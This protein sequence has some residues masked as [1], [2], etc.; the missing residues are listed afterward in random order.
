MNSLENPTD[1]WYLKTGNGEIY[2]PVNLAALQRWAAAGRIT[3]DALLSPDQAKWKPAY[4]L[5]ALAMNCVV[6]IRPGAFYG[7]LHANAVDVYARDGVIPASAAVYI[8]RSAAEPVELGET[9]H[10]I[11]NLEARIKND[12]AQAENHLAQTLAQRDAFR[13]HAAQLEHELTTASAEAAARRAECEALQNDNEALRIELELLRD[14][15]A[16][17][18]QALAE[19]EATLSQ[20]RATVQTLNESLR[21]L[22]GDCD[23]PVSLSSPELVPYTDTAAFDPTAPEVNSPLARLEAQVRVELSNLKKTGTFATLFKTA[24]K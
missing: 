23:E 11:S 17:T 19:N 16:A 1:I 22:S 7:P 8:T 5:D 20:F 4:L 13:Q 24:P 18:H 12:H 6:R 9:T 2:G 10:Q 3:P 14:K 15:Q 21:R